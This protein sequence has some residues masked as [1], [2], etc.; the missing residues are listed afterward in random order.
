MVREHQDES[1]SS[2]VVQ[3]CMTCELTTSLTLS[4]DEA[5]DTSGSVMGYTESS[6]KDGVVTQSAVLHGLS[7]T[8]K[9]ES[10]VDSGLDSMLVS[11]MNES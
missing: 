3:R 9:C 8:D 10:V 1:V 2:S 7:A 5:A 4:G 6:P 11:S